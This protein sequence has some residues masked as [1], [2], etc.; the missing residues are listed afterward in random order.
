[1][2]AMSRSITKPIRVTPV[3][4]R[5]AR[6]TVWHPIN[7][8]PTDDDRWTV[9]VW[10][11]LYDLLAITAGVVAFHIGSPF[12]NRLFAGWVVDAGAI[13]FIIGAV[14][15]L[16]GVTI[17]RLW[18][19]EIMGKLVI[20]LMLTSYAFL[21]LSFPSAGGISNLF[22]FAVLV[23]STWSI[24][25]RLTRLFIRGQRLTACRRQGT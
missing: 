5:L 16:V 24:Y 17:P 13:V 8:D 11:P 23:M 19:I 18:R 22:V 4:A 10:L 20:S 6:L 15:S 12:L 7:T 25:P 3:W 1:M 2:V 9:R 21:V 14:F